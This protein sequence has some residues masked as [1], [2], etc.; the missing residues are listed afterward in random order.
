MHC[1]TLYSALEIYLETRLHISRMLKRISADTP[2]LTPPTH[3]THCCLRKQ[4]GQKL[5]S[6]YGERYCTIV[7]LSALVTD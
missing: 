4:S 3:C 2:S 1:R 6:Q 5:V 7:C